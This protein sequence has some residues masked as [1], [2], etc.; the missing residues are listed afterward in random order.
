MVEINSTKKI[1]IHLNEDD[2]NMLEQLLTE[3]NHIRKEPSDGMGKFC[4]NFLTVLSKERV[5]RI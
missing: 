5:K 3:F 4:T 2:A 1:H